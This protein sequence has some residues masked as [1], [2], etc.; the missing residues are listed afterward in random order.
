MDDFKTI[1]VGE[2]TCQDVYEIA[3]LDS[4]MV[5]SYGAMCEYPTQDGRYICIKFYA[6]ELIVGLIKVR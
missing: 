2:S 3:P 4:L 6:S 1:K 5:T